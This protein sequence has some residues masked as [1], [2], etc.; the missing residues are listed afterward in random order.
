MDLLKIVANIA[1]KSVVGPFLDLDFDTG[2]GD[3]VFFDDSGGGSRDSGTIGPGTGT[4]TVNG[5]D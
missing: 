1:V 5:G 2:D 4:G 3:M